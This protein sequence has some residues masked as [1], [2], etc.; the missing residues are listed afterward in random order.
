MLLSFN[1]LKY[2][3]SRKSHWEKLATYLLALKVFQAC[4]TTQNIPAVVRITLIMSW[5][6][7]SQIGFII[8]SFYESFH[9]QVTY[10]AGHIPNANVYMGCSLYFKI[11][12]RKWAPQQFTVSQWRILPSTLTDLESIFLLFQGLQTQFYSHE[13]LGSMEL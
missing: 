3:Y 10:Q 4:V 2:Q 8:M 1:K 9:T 13:M 6:V 7:L 5:F 11:N 12:Y